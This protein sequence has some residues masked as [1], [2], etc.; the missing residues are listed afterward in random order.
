MTFCLAEQIFQ[1][2]LFI[3]FSFN[4]ET[5]FN[6]LVHF[7]CNMFAIYSGRHSAAVCTSVSGGAE[8]SADVAY[9]KFISPSKNVTLLIMFFM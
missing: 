7:V 3:W 5:V 1:I 2:S 8:W 6:S 9:R 4:G